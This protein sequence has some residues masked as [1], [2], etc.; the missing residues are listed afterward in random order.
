MAGGYREKMQLAGNRG[1]R[2][3]QLAGG[4]GGVDRDG[5]WV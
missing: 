1:R 4:Q 3:I 5:W 2:Y